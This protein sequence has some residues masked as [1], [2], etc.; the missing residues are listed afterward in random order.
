MNQEILFLRKQHSG[1][2]ADQYYSMPLKGQVAGIESSV[3]KNN[4]ELYYATKHLS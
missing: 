3:H 1:P 2:L 4:V